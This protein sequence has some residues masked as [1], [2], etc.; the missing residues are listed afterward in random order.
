MQ[1]LFAYG[2]LRPRC[3]NSDL[4][5]PSPIT[6]TDAVADGLALYRNATDTFP[7]AVPAAGRRVVGTLYTVL[8]LAWPAL[9]HRLDALEGYNPRQPD[10][11][12]L[13]PPAVDGS[14]RRPGSSEEA[15]IYLAGPRFRTDPDR[16][17]ESG[18]WMSRATR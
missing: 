13:P 4:L 16:L 8:D 14:C 12:S 2:T 6:A 11:Q 5:E 10:D 17:I 7:Y 3:A 9:R 1:H 15:W 18:D